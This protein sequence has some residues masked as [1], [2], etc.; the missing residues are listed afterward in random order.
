M[1]RPTIS[2]L[3]HA[4]SAGCDMHVPTL[5]SSVA[6]Q[7]ELGAY[8]AR[9]AGQA[10]AGARSVQVMRCA[11]L[12]HLRMA[13]CRACSSRLERRVV[14][15]T[16]LCDWMGRARSWEGAVCVCSGRTLYPCPL[17]RLLGSRRAVSGACAPR[18]ACPTASGLSDG[19]TRVSRGG[20]GCVGFA[21]AFTIM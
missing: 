11:P 17:L 18:A 4:S 13:L 3:S 21:S 2:R 9:R 10:G 7:C 20:G 1:R 12:L 6:V 15:A 16:P 8:W 14:G 5:A 19:G